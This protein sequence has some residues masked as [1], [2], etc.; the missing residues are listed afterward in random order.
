MIH[1][2]EQVLDYVSQLLTD[3]TGVRCDKHRKGPGEQYQDKHLEV[4]IRD[5]GTDGDNASDE[6]ESIIGACARVAPMLVRLTVKDKEISPE[7]TANTLSA[8]IEAA[9]ATPSGGGEHV[10]SDA[11]VSIQYQGMAE[12]D[13]DTLEAEMCQMSLVF[14]TSYRT[15]IGKPDTLI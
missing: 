8:Q 10:V 2:R 12:E 9:L 15:E 13:D 5:E 4:S 14:T 6:F 11:P 7:T 1:A 3:A